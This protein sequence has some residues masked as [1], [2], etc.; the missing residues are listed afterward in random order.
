MNNENNGSNDVDADQPAEIVD[1]HDTNVD[2][3]AE[4]VEKQ[5]AVEDQEA[6]EDSEHH[7]VAHGPD[8]EKRIEARTVERQTRCVKT[9]VHFKGSDEDTWKETIEVA[10]VSRNG[11]GLLVSRPCRVG[12]IL[13]M[14][15]DMPVEL[16]LY[17]H[18]APAYPV[19]GVVQNCTEVLEGETRSYHIGVAF[20]G[21]RLPAEYREDPSSTFRIVGVDENGLWTVA[22]AQRQFADRG[23]VRYWQSVEMSISRRDE[24]NKQIDRATVKTR[25]ISRGGMA[26][27]G[28]LDIEIGG[29]VKVSNKELSFFSMA[30]VK[31]RTDNPQ[32]D[33]MSLIHMQFDTPGFPVESL[34][35]EQVDD[36][37]TDSHPAPMAEAPQAGSLVS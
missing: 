35:F 24:T 1:D 22:R 7:D 17:D 11:A 4:V 36:G 29:R 6:I 20:I 9:V 33:S 19:A 23:H 15:M 3:A 34:K 25:D 30:T 10:T 16:R 13:S 27:W 2:E 18:F 21:K 31:N 12:Q 28:P 26:V 5:E 8:S 14:V 37:E 32:D